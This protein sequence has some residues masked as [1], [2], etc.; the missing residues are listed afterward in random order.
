MFVISIYRWGYFQGYLVNIGHYKDYFYRRTFD[1]T[2]AKQ[3]TDRTARNAVKKFYK[4]MRSTGYY[5]LKNEN[6]DDLEK[7]AVNLK[8][9][10]VLDSNRKD[11]LSVKGYLIRYLKSQN[12]TIDQGWIE[13]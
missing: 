9:I 12:L 2:E 10:F 6:V 7:K 5:N 4:T 1:L 13:I 8:K 11:S 3:F